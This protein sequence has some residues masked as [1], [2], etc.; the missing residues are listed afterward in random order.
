MTRSSK[1]GMLASRIQETCS[2]LQKSRSLQLYPRPYCD[3]WNQMF[4]GG[5]KE[6]AERGRNQQDWEGD[7]GK[8][9]TVNEQNCLKLGSSTLC[10]LADKHFR[11]QCCISRTVFSGATW[12]VVLRQQWDSL[13]EGHPHW[14][15]QSKDVESTHFWCRNL[16]EKNSEMPCIKLQQAEGGKKKQGELISNQPQAKTNRLLTY[17]NVY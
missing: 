15:Q 4:V 5:G 7:Q 3:S 12:H 16:P 13:Q 9:K 17:L 14:L 2:P 10:V 1:T 6:R 11:N 8:Q